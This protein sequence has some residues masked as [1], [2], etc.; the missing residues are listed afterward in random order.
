M[1]WNPAILNVANPI[2]WASDVDAVT[3]TRRTGSPG[4]YAIT[5]IYSGNG[6]LQEG[7]GMTYI[8]PG[9]AVENADAKL[10]ID[11]ATVA[12]LPS[13]EVGDTVTR[14]LDSKQF[15][16]VSTSTVTFQF[17]HLELI[18]KRGPLQYK[19]R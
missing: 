13:V 10:F 6:D 3:V 15:T 8:S 14:T 4:S 2:P 1:G 7:N 16:V 11:A 12:D 17:P 5:T 9:G 18:L 19:T